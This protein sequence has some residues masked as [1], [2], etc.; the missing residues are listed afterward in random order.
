VVGE[1]EIT[2][3]PAVYIMASKKHGTLYTGVTSALY[4]RVCNH[5]NK[6]FKGFTAKYDVNMLVWYEHHV[7]MHDAIRREKQ[8]KAWKRAWKIKTIEIM[9]PAWKDLHDH[10]D[11]D[12][13]LVT[14]KEDAGVHQHCGD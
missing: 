3:F 4:N 11:T 7:S 14:P 12:A 1:D 2:K 6:T 5:K 8:I 10:I 13:T 9:N